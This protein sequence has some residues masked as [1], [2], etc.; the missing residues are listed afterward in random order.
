MSTL[1]AYFRLSRVGWILV[2]EG[3][4]SALPSEDLPPSVG[5]AKSFVGLFART[6]CAK[7]CYVEK[8]SV[9]KRSSPLECPFKPISRFVEMTSREVR[10]AIH[11]KSKKD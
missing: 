8:E 2:R 9:A 1:G 5:I 4:I 6:C 11:K 3:V 10:E 7:R